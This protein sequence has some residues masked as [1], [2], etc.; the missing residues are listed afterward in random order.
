MMWAA[1]P[2]RWF[3]FQRASSGSQMEELWGYYK[4]RGQL[5]LNMMTIPR[6]HFH[7]LKRTILL[8]AAEA[9]ARLL[10]FDQIWASGCAAQIC[11]FLPSAFYTDTSWGKK[12]PSPKLLKSAHMHEINCSYRTQMRLSAQFFEPISFRP[13]NA[14]RGA[15]M[16][17]GSGSS[18]CL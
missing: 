1:D 8:L 7:F 3:H 11:N 18:W 2:P 14:F 6:W 5:T 16:Q 13:S 15:A 9:Q 4:V 17:P 12:F 10:I